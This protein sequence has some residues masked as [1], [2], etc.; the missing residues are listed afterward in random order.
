MVSWPAEGTLDVR[1][2]PK[3][4]QMETTTRLL[5]PEVVETLETDP[6][7]L[8]ELASELHAADLADL[9]QALSPELSQKLFTVLSAEQG[10]NILEHCEEDRRTELFES[11]A[12]ESMSAATA[13]TDVMAADDRADMLAELQ[14]ELR[15]QLLASMDE[16][17]SRDIR[18]L[19]AYK[20]DSAGSLMTT[21]YVALSANSTAEEA[22]EEI[23]VIA[24]EMETIYQAYA[25]DPNGTLLGVISLRDLVTS[26][27][28]STLAEIMNPNI[29]TIKAY[30]DQEEVVRLISKYD[31]LALP[32]VDHNHHLVG[33][34]TID[35]AIDVVEEEATEDVQRLGAVDPLEG[36]Y[37]TTPIIQ[38]IQARLPWLII[39]F[40]AVLLTPYVLEHYTR[41][42][43]AA[44][45][46]SWFVPL[47]VSS[48]GNS[49][50]QSA[51]LI[52]R[53]L[54]LGK[55]KPSHARKVLAR[56]AIV[57]VSL[58]VA[59][60][61]VGVAAILVRDATRITG[62]A[63]TIACS[64]IAV[65]TL[66]ALLGSGIPLLLQRL[67]IDPAVSSTPFIASIV[68]VTGLILYFEIASFFLR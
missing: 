57:G 39:L 44:I 33:I 11:L 34:I 17:E 51:S 2:T 25:V 54:A 31:L 28:G 47:I 16:A 58:G 5:L 22:I 60:A 14:P 23:R 53:A 24:Q 4:Y 64:L 36:A 6:Q 63:L 42:H 9:A 3:G 21:D 15:F 48:G 52:I 45:M 49:G 10:A 20:D 7:Q 66:G 27:K 65:V 41:M 12:G 19:L 46:L 50:T 40:M 37:I 43:P 38:L 55:I 67:G 35:D 32:V 1:F 56:E 13:I 61:S 30:D 26:P 18:Q 68:D 59:L 62:L 29:I 8:L